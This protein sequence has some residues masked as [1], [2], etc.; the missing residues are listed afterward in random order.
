MT[1]TG[2]PETIV[3]IKK[4]IQNHIAKNARVIDRNDQ[5][6]RFNNGETKWGPRK[7]G[8]CNWLKISTDAKRHVMIW[9]IDG[10]DYM[11]A[12]ARK[13]ADNVEEV[14]KKELNQIV[15][16]E[17]KDAPTYTVTCTGVSVGICRGELVDKP[18]T[19]PSS[20]KVR[21]MEP[22]EDDDEWF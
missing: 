3:E 12:E 7:K 4:W 21:E 1:E 2:M 8:L 9:T 15:P 16:I 19:E 10:S 17:F 18:T 11:K 22:V 6:R 20:A 5:I 14:I 13:L